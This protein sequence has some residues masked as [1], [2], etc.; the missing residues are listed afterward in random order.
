M[1]IMQHEAIGNTNCFRC[2]K[3]GWPFYK[4]DDKHI[5][6]E[7]CVQILV[8]QKLAAYGRHIKRT[9]PPAETGR[10]VPRHHCH[11]H[12]CTK[13]VHPK[14]FMCSSDWKQL[15]AG[16]AH[17]DILRFYRRGQEA[18]RRVS[19]NYIIAAQC[20]IAWLAAKQYPEDTDKVIK[21]AARVIAAWQDRADKDGIVIVPKLP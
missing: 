9:R 6:C 3:M 20:A 19:I 21:G 16:N 12:R 13:D 10:Q 15:V 7:D 8:K 14:Y 11:A 17:V 5:Y 4:G 2:K 18:D 1:I